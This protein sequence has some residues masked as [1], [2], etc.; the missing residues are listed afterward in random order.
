MTP[1]AVNI[2][3]EVLDEFALDFAARQKYPAAAAAESRGIEALPDVKVDL[4]CLSITGT[5][6]SRRRGVRK[7]E[8]ERDRPEARPERRRVDA[9][10]ARRSGDSGAIVLYVY[11]YISK[12][13]GKNQRLYFRRMLGEEKKDRM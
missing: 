2:L 7:A 4:H 6:A 9:F 1:A 13:G 5:G 10:S 3:K 8:R 11:I 12:K